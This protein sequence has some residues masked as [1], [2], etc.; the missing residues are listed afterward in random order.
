MEKNQ[1]L[2]WT[3]DVFRHKK[4]WCVVMWHRG[5]PYGWPGNIGGLTYPAYRSPQASL[6]CNSEQQSCPYGPWI[7]GNVLQVHVLPREEWLLQLC[8]SII[9]HRLAMSNDLHIIMLECKRYLSNRELREGLHW[10]VH[11]EQ[12]FLRKSSRDS[13]PM[14]L[15]DQT[16]LLCCKTGRRTM[17][18]PSKSGHVL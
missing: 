1:I 8:A 16:R 5:D 10:T 9:S 14:R 6:I 12:N 17:M 18:L 11:R 4:M 2:H 7:G 15:V 3:A 13:M